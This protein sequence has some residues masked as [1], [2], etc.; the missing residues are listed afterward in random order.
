MKCPICEYKTGNYLFISELKSY[1]IK[2]MYNDSENFVTKQF[3]KCD[4]FRR[5]SSYYC[6]EEIFKKLK[7]Y[8]QTNPE[9]TIM[10]TEN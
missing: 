6:Y 3:G 1:N 7:R 8:F 4:K 5:F 9:H 10:N 2:S